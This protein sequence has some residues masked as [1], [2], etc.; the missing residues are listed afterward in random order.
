MVINATCKCYAVYISDNNIQTQLK[1]QYN[2]YLYHQNTIDTLKG[3]KNLKIK[4]KLNNL[5]KPTLPSSALMLWNCLHCK[6]IYEFTK[7]FLIHKVIKY[8]KGKMRFAYV[9]VIQLKT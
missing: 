3:T 7:L 2:S 6:Y 5:Y 4:T 8:A 9:S 1:Q